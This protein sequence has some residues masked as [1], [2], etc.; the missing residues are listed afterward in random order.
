M[1]RIKSLTK[2]DNHGKPKYWS[3]EYGWTWEAMAEIYTEDQKAQMTL[4]KGGEWESC[5]V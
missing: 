4:P 5:Q 1:W 3:D 2:T